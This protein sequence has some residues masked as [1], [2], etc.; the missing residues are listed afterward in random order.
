MMNLLLTARHHFKVSSCNSSYSATWLGVRDP[1]SRAFCTALLEAKNRA[2]A[3]AITSISAGISEICR[4]EAAYS[5][6]RAVDL[7]VT[8]IKRDAAEDIAFWRNN[9]EQFADAYEGATSVMLPMNKQ[10][11]ELAAQLAIASDRQS[12]Y[13]Q[14]ICTLEMVARNACRIQAAAGQGRGHLRQCLDTC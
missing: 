10:L 11:A 12:R 3:D 9:S 8:L 4:R 1:A 14:R 2:A 7:A 13:R 6:D 5:P